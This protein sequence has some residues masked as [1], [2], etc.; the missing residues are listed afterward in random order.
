MPSARAIAGPVSRCR[1][2]WAIRCT[3]GRS[4]QRA[5]LRVLECCRHW[6]GPGDGRGGAERS[7]GLPLFFERVANGEVAVAK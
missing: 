2:S 7:N 5:T 6:R 3:A 4:R 1:R